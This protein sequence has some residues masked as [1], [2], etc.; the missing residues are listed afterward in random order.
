VKGLVLGALVLV[1]LD[2]I[3]TSPAA[4]L[5]T[6]LGRPSHWLAAWMDAGVPLIPQGHMSAAPPPTPA[7]ST[8]QPGLIPQ[9]FKK[10]I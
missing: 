2:L 8:P 6:I 3:L 5:S 4:R 10:F 7:S 9:I 1:G